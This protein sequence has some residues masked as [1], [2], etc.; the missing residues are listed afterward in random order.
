MRGLWMELPPC[1]PDTSGFASA[2]SG[3]DGM[4]LIDDVR[5]CCGNY[6]GSEETRRGIPIRVFVSELGNEDAVLGTEGVLTRRC[7]ALAE[8]LSPAFVL[9][10]GSPIAA[11]IGTDLEGVAGKLSRALGLPVSQVDL[12]GHGTYEEG[13]SKTLE[14]MAHALSGP[15]ERRKETVNI[16][17]ANHLDWSSGDMAALRKRI[18]D[19]SGLAGSAVYGGET[20]LS[21]LRGSGCAGLNWV[22]NV[23]GLR[24]AQWMQERYGIPFL[25]G[26]PFGAAWSRALLD[27][28]AKGGADWIPPA[29]GTGGGRALLIGEQYTCDALRRLLYENYGFSTVQ[30]CSFFRMDRG[31]M[32]SGDRRLR[33]EDELTQLLGEDFDLV[34][35]D[36]L[37]RRCGPSRGRWIDL[38]HIPVSARLYDDLRPS[39]LG[40]GA[41][42]WLAAALEHSDTEED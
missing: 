11:L 33:E 36:P 5:G 26:A 9:L 24:A 21:E 6:Y 13:L 19:G 28:A 40:A 16:L 12:S 41:D 29:P 30:V 1:S 18:A 15:G 10:C 27:Q 31:C 14:A 39:L 4:G 42:R 35:G 37:L 32:A 20:T 22:V 2:L 34:I 3:T 38:P 23:S 25:R 17:G 8:Q 7:R